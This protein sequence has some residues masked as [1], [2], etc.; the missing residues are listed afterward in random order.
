M[1]RDFN[2]EMEE[3]SRLSRSIMLLSVYTQHQSAVPDILTPKAILDDLCAAPAQLHR[4]VNPMFLQTMTKV[5]AQ[6][7][8]NP[9]QFAHAIHKHF[10]D[11]PI[12]LVF[13]AY[14]TFPSL[15]SFFYIPDL[16]ENSIRLVFALMNIDPGDIAAHFAAALYVSFPRFADSL[17]S[18]FFKMVRRDSKAECQFEM[19]IK[20]LNIACKYLSRSHCDLAKLI[21]DLGR[22]VFVHI[23]VDFLFI[24]TLKL[25]LECDVSSHF[26]Q[27]T[28]PLINDFRFM[29][30]HPDCDRL[31][32]VFGIMSS[33]SIIE[34]EYSI[35]GGYSGLNL[36]LYPSFLSAYEMR[37]LFGIINSL[38]KKHPNAEKAMKMCIPAM[39]TTFKSG[40]FEIFNSFTPVETQVP[41]QIIPYSLQKLPSPPANQEFVRSYGIISDYARK[42]KVDCLAIIEPGLF[43]DH[44]R[45]SEQFAQIR[46]LNDPGFK[47]FS[48]LQML[49]R[50]QTC[51][52]KFDEHLTMW[53]YERQY[54]V[55]MRHAKHQYNIF[56]NSF[57][58]QFG[59]FNNKPL[60]FRR[61][62]F[63]RQ[64]V[65]D[66]SKL[67]AKSLKTDVIFN[68]IILREVTALQTEIVAFLEMDV[69][70]RVI[71]I[72]QLIEESLE[73]EATLGQT[74]ILAAICAK[75]L[76]GDGREQFLESLFHFQQ[77][78]DALP[79]DNEF[80]RWLKQMWTCV[81][82]IVG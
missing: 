32:R 26:L 38:E 55:V 39:F 27:R 59:T 71:A 30:I 13:F 7:I 49:K 48:V 73:I 29:R 23:F 10:S 20:A 64:G 34:P 77:L 57:V 75:I 44:M 33:H 68:E 8:L 36:K 76:S 56:L 40:Q 35:Y 2:H 63:E 17:W 9:Q 45:S 28:C 41:S 4:L 69:W 15:F 74:G 46:I 42:K 3:L 12:D 22:T 66:V 82:A 72:P 54:R 53:Q 67:S 58:K 37:I 31:A 1:Q 51:F 47:L 25:H 61:K 19:F 5:L 62:I 80:S 21:W 50:T 81:Q 16:V 6:Y 11:E 65:F 78:D 14:A 43:P 24:P 79:T 52:A 60:E 70:D 18:H